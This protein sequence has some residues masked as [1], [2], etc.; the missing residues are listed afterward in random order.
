MPRRR[1]PNRVKSS[2]FLQPNA[3]VF[4]SP[5][6]APAVLYRLLTITD[7]PK[8]STG[9]M[10]TLTKE[11]IRKALD[12]GETIQEI[13]AFFQNHSRTGIPQNVEYLVNEVGGKH[14][15]IHIGKANLYIQTDTPFLMQELLA[16]KE[17]KAYT[18]RALSETI[19]LL[20]GENYDKLLKDLRKAGYLP[21]S[22]E[23]APV[24][25]I[26]SG[27]TKSAPS[28]FVDVPVEK[29]TKKP[30]GK[31]LNDLNW[32]KLEADDGKT[33]APSQEAVRANASMAKHPDL[34]KFILNQ[35]I[36][37]N[38]RV[39]IAYQEGEEGEASVYLLEPVKMLPHGVRA[40]D[41][42]DEEAVF[43]NVAYRVGAN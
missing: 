9:S 5:Y 18:A 7:V 27:S 3:E 4:V 40:Y 8:N 19:A 24:A 17:L 28:R 14:G 2:S 15:H 12:H 39:E 10:V 33:V 22:D 20:Q 30:I 43:G 23:D 21:V 41:M 31:T 42:T 6:L 29:P 1:N 36:R 37:N 35:G 16:R 38:L 34:I 11:A 13:V 26:S 32:D 25:K